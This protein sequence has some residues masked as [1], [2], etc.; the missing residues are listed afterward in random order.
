MIRREA[1]V[2]LRTGPSSFTNSDRM[3]TIQQ[4]NQLW[5][6][7]IPTYLLI[8]WMR[9]FDCIPIWTLA[10]V[11]WICNSRRLISRLW[12]NSNRKIWYVIL[13]FICHTDF[14]KHIVDHSR[15]PW[16]TAGIQKFRSKVSNDYPR[17]IFMFINLFYC[18]FRALPSQN[19][20]FMAFLEGFAGGKDN[21]DSLRLPL[22]VALLISPI[23]LLQDAQIHLSNFYVQ[24]HKMILVSI[25]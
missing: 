13:A 22:Q 3:L 19:D 17:H 16:F 23:F 18:I 11:W 2:D 20:S 9:C 8:S 15:F 24:R 4:Q 25:Y 21:V 12:C 1:C 14:R 10:R 7:T 5:M 6:S